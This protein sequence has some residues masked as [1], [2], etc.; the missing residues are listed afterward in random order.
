MNEKHL[1]ELLEGEHEAFKPVIRA[2]I[3]ASNNPVFLIGRL[4]NLA[5]VIEQDMNDE[6]NAIIGNINVANEETH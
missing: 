4:R 5:A 3:A 2:S 1:K 6:Q